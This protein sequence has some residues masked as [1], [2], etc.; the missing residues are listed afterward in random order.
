MFGLTA[1]FLLF[2]DT[3]DNRHEILSQTMCTA[4]CADEIST[5][6]SSNAAPSRS[7]ESYTSIVS[8]F[9]DTSDDAHHDIFTPTFDDGLEH[10]C[11][12]DLKQMF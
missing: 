3:P 1:C 7:F 6:T 11:R 8:R 10:L 4:V 9:Q 12:L 5:S 2:S